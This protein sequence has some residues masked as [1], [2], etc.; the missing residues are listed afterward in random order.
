MADN[1]I[2]AEYKLESKTVLYYTDKNSIYW[3]KN[4]SLSWR[5]QNPGDF[6]TKKQ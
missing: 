3:R 5:C 2:K 1:F 6:M 4:G